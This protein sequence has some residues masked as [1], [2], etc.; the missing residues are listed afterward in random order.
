MLL[1]FYTVRSKRIHFKT[2]TTTTA[3]ITTT[4][5]KSSSRKQKIGKLLG[6]HPVTKGS[7]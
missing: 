1:S 2:V 4:E 5:K 6:L 7:V 3:T